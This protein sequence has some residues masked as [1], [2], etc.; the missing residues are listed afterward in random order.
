MKEMANRG[1]DKGLGDWLDNQD[2]IV[3]LMFD[4]KFWNCQIPERQAQSVK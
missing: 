1:K 2:V 4:Y 3:A